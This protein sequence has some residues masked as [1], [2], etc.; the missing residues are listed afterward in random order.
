MK[1]VYGIDDNF[2]Q[3]ACASIISVIEHTQNPEIVILHKGLDTKPFEVFDCV[4]FY[5]VPDYWYKIFANIKVQD[6]YSPAT[7][8]RL[9]APLLFDDCLYIDADC[10]IET[11]VVEY[12]KS[13]K[14]CAAFSTN[15]VG[16]KHLLP[17]LA[18]FNLFRSIN[19]TEYK[20]KLSSVLANNPINDW[21]VLCRIFNDVEMFPDEDWCSTMVGIALHEKDHHKQLKYSQRY[22]ERY[23]TAKVLHY[24]MIPKD[25]DTPRMWT[26][27]GM[28]FWH[29]WLKYKVLTEK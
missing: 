1:I 19:K 12:C 23:K 2:S 22:L 24:S 11:D 28:K 26:D 7:F 5:E 16:G 25:L 17:Y 18:G 8:Y 13:Y 27:G 4:S 3:L 29:Y 20:N 6:R 9:L 10:I 21:F 15:G 14:G